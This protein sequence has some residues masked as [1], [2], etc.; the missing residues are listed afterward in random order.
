MLCLSLIFCCAGCTGRGSAAD[1]G[2]QLH[3]VSLTGGIPAS[4]S[5]AVLEKELLL[6][7]AAVS[8]GYLLPKGG[9]EKYSLN[10]ELLW[11]QKYPFIPEDDLYYYIHIFPSDDDSFLISFVVPTYQKPDGTMC[12]TAPV[13][14]KCDRNGRLLWQKSYAGFGDMTLDKAFLLPDGNA[15]TIGYTSDAAGTDDIYL[16]LLDK[17]GSLIGEKRYGGSDFDSP[18]DADYVDGVG[19]VALVT[20]QSRDGTFSASTDGYGVDVLLLLDEHLNIKWQRPLSSLLAPGSLLATDEVIYLLDLQNN[21]YKVDF[22]GEVVDQVKLFEKEAEAHFVG[23]S[24]YG[25]LLQCENELVFYHD[26][27][28]GMKL[29]FNAGRAERVIDAE[30]GFII[31]SVNTTG[32]LPTPPYISALWYSTELVYSGYDRSGK[33]LWRNACDNTPAHIS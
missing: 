20:T 9:V 3:S 2:S 15:V 32:S 4:Y 24:K 31:V 22:L 18:N 6:N 27:N 10:G 33:L 23:N 14:A 28:A 12:T 26:R 11:T 25:V 16:S 17:N 19:L 29:D 21:Y 8:D 30:D 1:T 7:A 13:L 5:G